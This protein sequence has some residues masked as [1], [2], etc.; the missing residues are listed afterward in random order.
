MRGVTAVYR[1]SRVPPH[2]RSLNFLR[3]KGRLDVSMAVTYVTFAFK[4][5]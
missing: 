2:P 3:V 1:V 4:N 5:R